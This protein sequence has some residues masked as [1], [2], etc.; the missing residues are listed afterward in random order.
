M[1]FWLLIWEVQ[2][3]TGQRIFPFWYNDEV[4]TF[5]FL[6]PLFAMWWFI[7]LT[8]FWVTGATV[9]AIYSLQLLWTSTIWARWR[10]KKDFVSSEVRTL[11]VQPSS[12]LA[13]FEI[14]STLEWWSPTISLS[15]SLEIC[16]LL[17]FKNLF[18][19]WYN[20][21]KNKIKSEGRSNYK[22]LLICT[23][24]NNLSYIKMIRFDLDEIYW[25]IIS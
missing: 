13:I 6:F 19:A 3:T 20:R 22:H 14:N 12:W 11:H 9:F 23:S 4:N 21:Q 8:K 16:G 5:F 18:N 1:V 2:I 24:I 15:Y 10:T 25:I 17:Q 7:I